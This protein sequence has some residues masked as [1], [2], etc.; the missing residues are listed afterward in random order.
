MEHGFYWISFKN[1]EECFIG[2]YD[3]KTNKIMLTGDPREYN[4]DEFIIERTTKIEFGECPP[5]HS[6]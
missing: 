5:S 4:I 3:K 6:I 1:E 2:E